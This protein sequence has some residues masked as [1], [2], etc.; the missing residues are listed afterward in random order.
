MSERAGCGGCYA[1]TGGE[2]C[3]K[4]VCLPEVGMLAGRWR[5]GKGRA[6]ACWRLRRP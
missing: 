4:S 2:V 3:V 1:V 5:C 6:K